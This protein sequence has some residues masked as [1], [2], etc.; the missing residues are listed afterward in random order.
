MPPDD[1]PVRK[2]KC[3]CSYWLYL[4]KRHSRS[5]AVSSVGSVLLNQPGMLETF[6]VDGWDGDSGE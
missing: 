1:E 3:M 6:I 2:T 5:G 4:S